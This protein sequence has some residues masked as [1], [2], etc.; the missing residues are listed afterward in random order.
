[1]WSSWIYILIEVP[2]ISIRFQFLSPNCLKKRIMIWSLVKTLKN[3][4]CAGV[5]RT[6]RANCTWGE[7][8]F[9]FAHQIAIAIALCAYISFAAGAVP[10]LHMC[11]TRAEIKPKRICLLSTWT[12][13]P[14]PAPLGMFLW[15][16]MCCVVLCYVAFLL[17]SVGC[18]CCWCKARFKHST[19][20]LRVPSLFYLVYWFAICRS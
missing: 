12:Q 14:H 11:W 19:V 10:F 18:W 16:M 4:G 13:R 8:W 3:N 20:D 17:L 1:M 6:A 7:A 15:C 2:K 5:T 9:L